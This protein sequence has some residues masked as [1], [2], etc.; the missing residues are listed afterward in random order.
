MII[1]LRNW[2]ELYG[3]LTNSSQHIHTTLSIPTLAQLIEMTLNSPDILWNFLLSPLMSVLFCEILVDW[4]KHAF[5]TKFNYIKPTVYSNFV[6]V[7]C[8]DWTRNLTGED[9][10][11]KLNVILVFIFS[12][13][14]IDPCLYLEGWGFLLYLLLV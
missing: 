3:P 12:I 2:V 9:S 1:A 7:L 4:L 8:K 14:S 11:E 13:K 10:K 5:V 6:D